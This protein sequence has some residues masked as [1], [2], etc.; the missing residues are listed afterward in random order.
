[1]HCLQYHWH[2]LIALD[3]LYVKIDRIATKILSKM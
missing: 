1:M 2:H 3:V